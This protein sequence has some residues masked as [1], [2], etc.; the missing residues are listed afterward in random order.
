M[1]PAC[2]FGF[3][4]RIHKTITIFVVVVKFYCPFA[5]HQNRDLRFALTE[6]KTTNPKI[7]LTLNA[8]LHLHSL[9]PPLNGLCQRY[10]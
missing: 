3:V 5:P 10:R 4:I 1:F 6:S 7:I 8:Y 2:W 9:S